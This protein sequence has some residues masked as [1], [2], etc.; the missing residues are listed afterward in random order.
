MTGLGW[1]H[2]ERFT[3]VR[4]AI[5]MQV[6]TAGTRDA[7]LYSSQS[8]SKRGSGTITRASSGLI[9]AYGKLAAF[10]RSEFAS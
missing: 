5:S 10:P 1:E 9:V 4:P 3:A 7:G 6:R 2:R 8:Q